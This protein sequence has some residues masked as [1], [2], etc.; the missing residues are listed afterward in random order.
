MQQ[1]PITHGAQS[2]CCDHLP[3]TAEGSMDPQVTPFISAGLGAQGGTSA[4]L[5]ITVPALLHSK[6]SDHQAK[7]LFYPEFLT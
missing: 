4:A 7:S 1:A 3:P 5:L 6:L 2:L